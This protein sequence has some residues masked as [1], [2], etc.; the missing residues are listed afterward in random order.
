MSDS[1]ND[2]VILVTGGGR[3]IGAAIVQELHARGARL[4]VHYRRSEAEA[5]ALAAELNAARADSAHC[6]A[7]DLLDSAALQALAEAAGARWGRLDGLV[8]NASSF[9]PTPLG[10]VQE[11]DWADL[12][13]SN[14]KAPLF[15]TQAA[16][17]A[18]RQ[19]A[20]AVVN[21]VD[22][23]SQRSL[24]AHSLYTAA[25]AALVS[26][27]RGLARDLAPQVRV[28]GVAPGVILWPEHNAPAAAAEQA[29]LQRVPMQRMG[30]PA[31]IARAVAFLLS[32]EAAYV[33]GQILAVDGGASLV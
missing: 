30:E 8:N 26:L 9:Y 16:A 15:L 22:I 18:L 25:K 13:G 20:G 21:I 27:T 2:K 17:P 28:N 1:L 5:Q 33:T 32:A 4:L 31:D 3:R 6:L 10:E 14:F 24:A 29:L 19:A 12:A 11:T 23:H 7:A